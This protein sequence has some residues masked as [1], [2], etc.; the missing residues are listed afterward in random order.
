MVCKLSQKLCRSVNISASAVRKDLF[1][2]V[3]IPMTS[4]E[5]PFLEIFLHGNC[6]LTIVPIMLCFTRK[7]MT[8][9]N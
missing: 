1:V 5:L 6:S 8:L 3:K 4:V 2:R 9:K 7:N